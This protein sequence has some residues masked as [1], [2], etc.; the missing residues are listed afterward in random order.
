MLL[1]DEKLRTPWCQEI[2]T[3]QGQAEFC[4]Q[5]LSP[6][7]IRKHKAVYCI[8]RS[9]FITCYLCDDFGQL[10]HQLNINAVKWNVFTSINFTSVNIQETRI[11][12]LE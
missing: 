11:L 7:N 4:L 3:T 8:L 9:S 1:S 5:T 6:I 10:I 12:A 2:N